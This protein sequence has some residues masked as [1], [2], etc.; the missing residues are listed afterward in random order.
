MLS[1]LLSIHKIY[2]PK[3]KQEL[4]NIVCESNFHTSLPDFLL[5]ILL[6]HIC[7]LIKS[8][9]YSLPCNPPPS[10]PLFPPIL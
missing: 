8:A 2:N 7:V 10:L 5:L 1:F 3:Q 4:N 6:A 9:P